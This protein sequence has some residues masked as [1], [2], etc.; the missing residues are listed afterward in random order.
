MNRSLKI[1]LL[2]LALSVMLA[3][4]QRSSSANKHEA[5]VKKRSNDF[6][7]AFVRLTDGYWQLWTMDPDGSSQ[8]QITTT[9]YDKRYP[10]WKSRNEIIFRTN[11]HK[12]FV[13]DLAGKEKQLLSTVNQVGGVAS[14]PTSEDLLFVRIKDHHT[15]VYNLWLAKPDGED[16][17]ML[18]YAGGKQY[19]PAWSHDGEKIAYIQFDGYRNESVCLIDK[20][21]NDEV[22]KLTDG[23]GFNF[24]PSFSPDDKQI[25][26]VSDVSGDN[27]IWLVDISSKE[28]SQLTHSRGIDTRPSWTPDG[29]QICFMSNRTGTPQIYM[30][31]KDGSG[32]RQLTSSTAVIDPV[33]G[34][35]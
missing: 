32:V 34:K 19:D 28:T 35:D 30:M 20:E 13:T 6:K 33:C 9:Q 21:G 15:N 2:M 7:I 11:N 8:K 3:G 23:R 5:E 24:L 27:E 4:C 22:A 31:N 14:S 10:V 12:V 18:T 1:C 16:S 26:Y 25:T 29:E 17:R